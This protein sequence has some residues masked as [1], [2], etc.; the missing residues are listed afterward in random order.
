[1]DPQR[2]HV[3]WHFGR[4]QVFPNIK[5]EPVVPLTL[6]IFKQDVIQP[7]TT[8]N[9]ITGCERPQSYDVLLEAGKTHQEISLP[10]SLSSAARLTAELGKSDTEQAFT[11][12]L[13][14]NAAE[15]PKPHL[16][17]A[18]YVLPEVI[19]QFIMPGMLTSSVTS[20]ICITQE[21]TELR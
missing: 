1:V 4:N 6:R 11:V 10:T 21:S 5:S 13:K 20:K 12:L 7:A 19:A 8:Q 15:V 16:E 17:T 9:S 3:Y 18:N 14:S 2:L